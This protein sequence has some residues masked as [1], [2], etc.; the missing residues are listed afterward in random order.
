MSDDL[1]LTVVFNFKSQEQKSEFYKN[2]I[3][4]NWILDDNPNSFVSAVSNKDE[5]LKM[6]LIEFGREI[7]DI[8]FIGQVLD[9][10]ELPELEEIRNRCCE[11][12]NEHSCTESHAYEELYVNV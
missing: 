4:G 5:M 1:T 2:N 12:A 8:G 3:D 6:E 9:E 11:Y 10:E 7:D